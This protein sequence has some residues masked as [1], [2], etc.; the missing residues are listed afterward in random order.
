MLK[1]FWLE[2]LC[3]FSI[4]GKTARKIDHNWPR[5]LMAASIGGREHWWPRALV[6]A[7]IG[8]REPWWPQ[9]LWPRALMA[10]SIDDREL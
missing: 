7:R 4:C 6:A 10:A 8:G 9:A 3:L 1:V 2:M 5:A